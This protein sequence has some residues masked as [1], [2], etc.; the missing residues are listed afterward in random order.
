MSKKSLIVVAIVTLAFA[1]ALMLNA[2][3]SAGTEATRLH[4]YVGFRADGKLATNLEVTAHR[5]GDCD[6]RS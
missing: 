4:V 3:V 2:K 6:G 1:V 5:G